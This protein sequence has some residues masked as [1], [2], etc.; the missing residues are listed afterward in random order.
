LHI[1]FRGAR[2]AHDGLVV[3]VA[4]DAEAGDR[5][6]GGLDAVDDL[7]RPPI[8]DADHHHRRHVRIGARA[9]QRAEVQ[10]QVRAELQPSVGC[11]IA[12][13]P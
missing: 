13:A 5:L 6:A 9:D 12:I 11:G 1:L 3:A 10:L 7:L 8:L 2:S 4:L